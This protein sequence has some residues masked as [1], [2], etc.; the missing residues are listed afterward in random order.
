MSMKKLIKKYMNKISE[1]IGRQCGNP[2]GIV[3]RICCL[4]MNIINSPMYRTIISDVKADHKSRILDVGCGNGFFISQLC[5]NT[6]AR[7]YGI[8]ISDDMIHATAVRN[9]KAVAEKRLRLSVGN[10]CNLKFRDSAFDTVTTI[11]TIYFWNDTVKGLSEIRRVLKD[12]G[13]FYNAV[14]TKEWLKKIPY[15]RNVFKFFEKDDYIKL[16]KK[17]G[18]S[19]VEVREIVEG[20]SYI[21]KYTK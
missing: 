4:S 5:K 15:T 18:F 3:G 14:Y 19:S 20:K 6:K 10:C 17:A 13:V 8:D 1:Y 9:R 21:I 7:L 2:H 11:N 12:N 16:S